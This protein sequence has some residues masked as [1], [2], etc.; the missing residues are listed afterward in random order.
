[1]KNALRASAIVTLAAAAFPS[2]SG[3]GSLPVRAQVHEMDLLEPMLLARPAAAV[4][5]GQMT[6]SAVKQGTSLGVL[7][8]GSVT[9]L[10]IPDDPSP[11]T[12]PATPPPK[13]NN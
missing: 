13:P 6:P 12:L 4:P 5:G 7:P 3:L 2:L 11:P 9:P 1:M 8:G 10:P